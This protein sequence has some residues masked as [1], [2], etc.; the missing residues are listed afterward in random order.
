MRRLTMLW[1]AQH[2]APGINRSSIDLMV[3]QG[4]LTLKATR[5]FSTGEQE[6]G[7]PGTPAA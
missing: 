7:T 2:A 5:S 1:C 4:V 3:N 6:K